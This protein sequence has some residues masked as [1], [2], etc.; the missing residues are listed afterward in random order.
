MFI[1]KKN[2]IVLCMIVFGCN[3]INMKN[4]FNNNFFHLSNTKQLTF[5]GDNGEAYFSN[6]D[7]KL[8]FQSKRDGNQCDKIY[9]MSVDGENIKILPGTYNVVVST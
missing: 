3:Q 2:I 7:E 8:I 6:N 4:N 1:L 5:I 9:T